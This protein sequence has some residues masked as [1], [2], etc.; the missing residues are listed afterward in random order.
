MH[1]PTRG[2]PNRYHDFEDE[3]EVVS[4]FQTGE[5]MSQQAEC[6]RGPPEAA[7]RAGYPKTQAQPETSQK[8]LF[9][10]LGPN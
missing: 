3:G 2:F 5:P 7:A 6:W 1:T 9:T 8:H 10:D 4:R